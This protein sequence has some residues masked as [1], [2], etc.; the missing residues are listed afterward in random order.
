MSSKP[1]DASVSTGRRVRSIAAVH[2]H[3]AI[4]TVATGSLLLFRRDLQPSDH[5]NRDGSMKQTPPQQDE[6]DRARIDRAFSC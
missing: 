2:F 5:P 6:L 4:C 3:S 1:L